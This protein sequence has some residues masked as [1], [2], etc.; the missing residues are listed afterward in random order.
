MFDA[1]ALY[2]VNA[3]VELG[4]AI[5]NLGQDDYEY[6]WFDGA[7]TLHSPANRRNVTASIR[8]TF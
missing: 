7:Q 2:R 8:L 5:K 1:S 4:L 3:Q 6:V